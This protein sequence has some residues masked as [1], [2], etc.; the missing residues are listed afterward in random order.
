M[1][2]S[3]EENPQMMLYALGAYDACKLFYPIKQIRLAIVQPR[4]PD[5]ISEWG[6][7]L[8][9]LL[10]FGDYV[11]EKAAV[12]FKGDGEFVPGEKQCRF[13]RA[14]SQCRA[15]AEENVK[16]AFATDKK[17]PL[18]TNEEVG[19]YLEQ[20]E[21]VARWLKDLQEFAL[22]ECL[23]GKKIPGWKAVEGRGS[24]DWTDMDTAFEKTFKEWDYR[25]A[26]AVGKETADFGAGRKADREER[27]SGRSRRVCGEEARETDTC[28]RV[29]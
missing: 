3:V 2:V 25:R 5:G 19:R 28:K 8:E 1:P 26:D 21:D 7:S 6:C 11:K 15:R 13:C 29:R 18:I 23:A 22:S 12:A 24:R 10:K 20:G 17:P 14:K 9:Q 27:F 16:L 4:L